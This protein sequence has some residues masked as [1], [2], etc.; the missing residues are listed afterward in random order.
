VPYFEAAPGSA[1]RSIVAAVARQESAFDARAVS[2]AG[3][4]GLMQLMPATAAAT[5]RFF[6][7]PFAL[8][9]LTAEPAANARIGAAHLGQLLQAF[10]GSY[11]LTFASYNAG[12]RRAKEWIAAYG[13]PRDPRIDVVDWIERIPISETRNY[14][15]RVAENAIV[16]SALF[17]SRDGRSLRAALAG[18]KRE[19]PISTG[20]LPPPQDARA[21]ALAAAD[22]QR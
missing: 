5:A 3:A 22:A 19:E 7:L 21:A 11:V 18:S 13:D 17:G 2:H 1:G 9:A 15:Q 14:V 12:P 6:K 16:Y 20:S 10:G 4:R 8:P